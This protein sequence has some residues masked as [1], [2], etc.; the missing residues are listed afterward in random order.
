M[1]EE[2]APEHHDAIP[3]VDNGIDKASKKY[4]ELATAILDTFSSANEFDEEIDSVSWADPAIGETYILYR[5]NENT[6]DMISSSFWKENIT[7]PERETILDAYMPFKFKDMIVLNVKMDYPDGQVTYTSWER[8]EYN[9]A[10]TAQRTLTREQEAAR[11]A[12]LDAIPQPAAGI[13]FT[14][15]LYSDHAHEIDLLTDVLKKGQEKLQAI[16]K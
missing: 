2:L 6:K 15:D 8:L 9:S 16:Q 11:K 4:V 7:N 1:T 10:L 14:I 12:K 13:K 5:Y 3:W